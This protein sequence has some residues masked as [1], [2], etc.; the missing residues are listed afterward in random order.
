MKADPSP[1]TFRD[2]RERRAGGALVTFSAQPSTVL[3]ELP[4]CVYEEF[5]SFSCSGFILVE[6]DLRPWWKEVHLRR[7]VGCQWVTY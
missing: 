1:A 6:S 3:C 4:L 5:A 7:H 2:G